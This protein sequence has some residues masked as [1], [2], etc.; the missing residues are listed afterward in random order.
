MGIELEVNGTEKEV[1]PFRADILCK[2]METDQWVLIEN[3]LERTDHSHLGQILTYAA[4]LKAN[5]VIWIASQF[6][7]EHRA[8][9]DWLN[10]IT[11][12]DYN[13][14][15][16]EIQLWR[17]GDSPFA[18]RFNIVSK[19]NRWTRSVR[20]SVEHPELTEL[21]RKQLDFWTGFATYMKEQ[22]SLIKCSR[23]QPHQ[24]IVHPIGRKFF[25]LESHMN[26]SGVLRVELVTN[27]VRSKELMAVLKQKQNEI[28]QEMGF[29]LVFY[30]P[31]DQRRGR[32]YIQKD[33][34]VKNQDE[35]ME[36]YKWL[37]ET[38]EQ[39]Y[40]AFHPRTEMNMMMQQMEDLKDR[41]PS[42]NSV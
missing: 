38:L 26:L 6:T 20:E 1:G 40:K 18:P 24:C 35:W 23:I 3:Q 7:E 13:F 5:T 14:F 33:A 15:G 8:A 32:I 28:E 9:I 16:V 30:N 37:K 29:A 34:D 25:Q 22:N 31:E 17:I 27:D 10:E 42:A 21:R 11:G 12:E 36:H 4:G 41:V 2:D 19:P 39:F